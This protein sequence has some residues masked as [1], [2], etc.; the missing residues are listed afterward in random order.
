M[1]SHFNLHSNLLWITKIPKTTTELRF[2]DNDNFIIPNFGN[3]IV[4]EMIKRNHVRLARNPSGE[5]STPSS[6]ISVLNHQFGSGISG[7]FCCSFRSS[8]QQMSMGSS[9]IQFEYP[10]PIIIPRNTRFNF[11]SE[12]PGY[13]QVISWFNSHCIII[14]GKLV[15][16]PN[17]IKRTGPM[18]DLFWVHVVSSFHPC[19]KSRCSPV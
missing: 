11:G 12:I 5:G 17:I 18:L 6:R 4:V 13:Q 14:W 10:T 3:W 16:Y 9:P 8:S 19:S 15:R 1:V 7:H 2:D